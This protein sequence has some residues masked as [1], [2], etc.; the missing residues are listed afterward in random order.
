MTAIMP[1][2]RRFFLASSTTALGAFVLGF[3]PQVGAQETAA[4]EV[5]HW[6]VTHPDN[7]VVFRLTRSEMGQG[8]LTGLAQLLAEELECDWQHVRTEYVSPRKNLVRGEVWG[9]FQTDGSGSIRELQEPLRHAGAAAR[10]MLIAAAATRWNVPPEECRVAAGL[11]H[12]PRTKRHVTYGEVAALAAAFEPPSIVPLKNPESWRIAG[13]PL[14]RLDTPDKLTGKQVY[15]IDV[16]LSG[17]LNAAVRACPIAGGSLKRFNAEAALAL[18]GMRHVLKIDDT[19][20]AVV[21]DRWWQANTALE[22]LEIVWE[23]ALGACHHRPG[24]VAAPLGAAVLP[25][26]DHPPGRPI[27][28]PAARSVVSIAPPIDRTSSSA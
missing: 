4:G 11:I 18:P 12:H 8:S 26:Q 13:Q 15:A 20:V 16:T 21:A 2:S 24:Q 17:M 22:A 14:R 5:N 3:A 28:S 23:P 9:D 7:T 1:M 10:I 27:A 6:I 19:A 25:Y